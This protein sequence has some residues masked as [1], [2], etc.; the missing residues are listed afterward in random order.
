VAYWPGPAEDFWAS[1]GTTFEQEL[2]RYHAVIHLRT[3]ALEHGYNQQNPLRIESAAEA[4]A[5]DR[6]IAQAWAKHPRRFA[7][8]CSVNFL[9]KAAR[10]IAIL[11]HE[12]LDCCRGH[13]GALAGVQHAA[14]LE[15]C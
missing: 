15:K 14:A 5:I 2:R 12:T 10:A 9:D 6:R 13:S 8:E 7:V 1:T 4:A 11:Q 3:P